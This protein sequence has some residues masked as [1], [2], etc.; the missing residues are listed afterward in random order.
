MRRS[1]VLLATLLMAGS[2]LSLHAQSALATTITLAV[3]PSGSVPF[4]QTVTLTATITDSNNAA[5]LHGSVTFYD[6]TLALG[7]SYIIS[8]SSGGFTP[9]TAILRTRSLAQTSHSLTATFN[10]TAA[11]RKSTSAAQSLTITAAAGPYPTATALTAAPVS[12]G[13]WNLTADVSGLGPLGPT[14]NVT[15]NDTT[16]SRA[17]GQATLGTSAPN[18]T[19]VGNSALLSSLTQLSEGA[20]TCL[21]VVASGDFDNDGYTDLLVAQAQETTYGCGGLVSLEVE[22]GDG[23]GDFTAGPVNSGSSGSEEQQ[24]L[25]T[26]VA[27]VNGDGIPDLLLVNIRDANYV[28]LTCLGNGDGSFQA[29]ITTTIPNG[30]LIATADFNNDGI[31]DLAYSYPTGSGMEVVVLLGQGDGTF[32]NTASTTNVPFSE[33]IPPFGAVNI[34]AGALTS[35]GNAG[36]LVGWGQQ[37]AVLAGEGNGSLQPPVVLSIGDQNTPGVDEQDVLSVALADLRN[38]GN[39]DIVALSAQTAA[40]PP[41]GAPIYSNQISILPG[42]SSGT[43]S[44]YTN[45]TLP[46]PCLAS[47]LGFLIGDFGFTGVPDVLLPVVSYATGTSCLLIGNGD[48]TLQSPVTVSLSPSANSLIEG[49]FTNSGGAELAGALPYNYYS[50][51]LSA[52]VYVP[53]LVATATLN[54]VNPGGTGTQLADASYA[55]DVN[56]AASSSAAIPLLGSGKV[57]ISFATAAIDG[58]SSFSLLAGYGT[59][60]TVSIA[61][62]P[63]GGPTPTGTLQLIV[64]GSPSGAPLTLSDGSASTPIEWSTPGTYKLQTTYSGDSNYGATSSGILN[65]TVL[66]SNVPTS[67]MFTQATLPTVPSG[68]PFTTTVEV[69]RSAPGPLPTG[70]VTVTGG[71]AYAQGPLSGTPATTTVTLNTPSQPMLVGSQSLT[72]NYPGDTLWAGNSSLNGQTVTITGTTTLTIDYSGLSTVNSGSPVTITG[73]LKSDQ[74]GSAPTGTVNLMDNGSVIGTWYL[75]GS[76]PFSL[77]FTV[78]TMSRP[79]ADGSNQL[80]LSYSGDSSWAASTSSTVTINANAAASM[81]LTSNLPSPL[82]ALPGATVQF[83]ATVTALGGGP[84]ATGTVQF[85]DGTTK[86]GAPVTLASNAASYSST[87]FAAGQHSITAVYS[88][89]SNYPTQTSPAIVFT[90]SGLGTTSLAVTWPSVILVDQAFNQPVMLQESPAEAGPVPTGTITVTSGAA[91][92]GSG[93]VP[94]N[95]SSPCPV[96]VTITQPIAGTGEAATISYSGDSNWQAGSLAS[97]LPTVEQG[98]PSLSSVSCTPLS[99]LVGVQIT[100]DGTLYASWR[101]PVISPTGSVELLNNGLVVATVPLSPVLGDSKQYNFNFNLNTQSQPLT[102]GTYTFGLYYSGDNSW[103]SEAS[104]AGPG[105]SVMVQ[106]NVP[107]FT[108]TSSLGTYPSAVQGTP[109]TFTATALSCNCGDGLPTGTVQ[110]FIDGTA[111]GSP[112][113]LVNGVASYTTSSLTQGTHTATAAYSG[114]NLYSATTTNGTVVIVPQGPDTLAMTIS[115]P[116]TVPLGSTIPVSGTMTVGA[117]GPVPSGSVALVDGATNIATAT[118]SGKP[119]YA[120]SFNVNT[121]SSPLAP[122]THKFSLA[123][124]GS[125]QWAASTSSTASVTVS[126][127]TTTTAVTSSADTADAGASVIFTAMVSS[128]VTSPAP[129]GTVQ[130]YDGGTA[131]GSAVTLSGK[132]AAYTT[133]SL[134]GGNHSITAAYSGDTDF[135]ASTS[136]ALTE[137]IESIAL[138]STAIAGT[139]SPGQSASY[140]LTLTADGVN[141]STSFACSSLPK[142]AACSLNPQTVTGS[143]STKL[144]ITTTGS[145]AATMPNPLKLWTARGAPVLACVVLLIAPARRRKHLLFLMLIAIVPALVAGCGGGSGC[146]MNCGGGNSTP[147]GTYTIKVTSTT[148]SGSSAIT[149][150][151]TVTLTV[152]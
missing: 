13:V 126:Q 120:L 123:Y 64:N 65:L 112:V 105:D 131:L 130:F 125:T 142:G 57:A 79:F 69:A 17:L 20:T 5:V 1:L 107:P 137:T 115:G 42:N 60:L 133:T 52:V 16:I 151:T 98:S 23:T 38:D 37:V 101:Y 70:T 122:G 150:T 106:A 109:V 148:G 40:S 3:G 86:I 111:A 127:A 93:N 146:G 14:G 118:V 10:G 113:P 119:P 136:T 54:N 92:L 56:F 34:A 141:E 72:A 48:A 49:D 91:T 135:S 99:A 59:T 9:G 74:T 45:V 12:S 124:A 50:T 66:S 144:T 55:G 2:S 96:P 83:T 68:T 149:A 22:L 139:V 67:V 47:G 104:P 129:T 4:E 18:F 76:S 46:S 41:A 39:V 134:T 132:T 19:L 138:S 103:Q 145:S 143:G 29:P 110:F 147:A 85:Y 108:L 71:G 97:T 77:S 88:G 116:S 62:I 58:V 51:T 80:S 102:A 35:G 27:D 6:G 78:N 15:F 21:T 117:L 31:P 152:Q 94:A 53:A 30:S 82:L 90:V 81:A 7:T 8:N 25:Q 63:S 87:S 32:P 95:C 73:Q 84:A 100:C 140:T 36:I 128:T 121:A 24:A 28:L 33:G 61:S 11:D 43:Y 114:D 44:S 75:S 26:I 89:D